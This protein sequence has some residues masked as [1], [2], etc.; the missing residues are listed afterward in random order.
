MGKTAG[1]IRQAG[2]DPIQHEQMVVNFL[3][4]RNR[5]KRQE[6]A[7]L[8]QIGPY[9]ATRLLDKLVKNDKLQRIGR[10][11]S[12]YYVLINERQ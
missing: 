12:T 2:F 3:K 4:K 7:E 9:Q 6:V 1:Y 11:R 10:H 5:I 8:C